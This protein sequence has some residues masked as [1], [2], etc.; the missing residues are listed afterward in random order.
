MVSS[1]WAVCENDVSSGYVQAENTVFEQMA[2]QGQSVFGAEGDTGAFSCIRSDGTTIVNVARP[3][4][5]ALGHQR[6]RTSLETDNPGT[7]PHPAYP[8]GR[9]DRVEH[10]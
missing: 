6:G 2:L 4:V 1:S 9:R 7:E 3:A 5:P 10:R 8:T